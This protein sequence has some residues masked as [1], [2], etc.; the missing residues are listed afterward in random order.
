[1]LLACE[2]GIASSRQRRRAQAMIDR[3][4]A[5]RAMLY[6]MRTSLGDV[7]ALLPMPVLAEQHDRLPA[8]ARVTDRLDEVWAA[9]R[10]L[11]DRVSARG[12]PDSG[13]IE[14][15]GAGG[16]GLGA[17]ALSAKV[18]AVCLAV[19]GTGA[20]CVDVVD[21]LKQRPAKAAPAPH[22]ARARQR[23][24]EPARDHVEIVRLPTTPSKTK[25][26]KVTAR[27]RDT[28]V[29]SPKSTSPASPAPKAS[30]EFGPGKL[31]STSA[32]RQPAPAPANGGGEFAP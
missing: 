10:H 32:T 20:I 24:V 21:H 31:G 8:L 5:C 7:A 4:P 3:D 16:A 13:V 1:L 6:A 29:S 25:T 17:G 9:A 19:G 14:Q 30:T 26:I 22:H 11:G 15:A 18:I 23:V 28:P 12:L 27:K 2:L